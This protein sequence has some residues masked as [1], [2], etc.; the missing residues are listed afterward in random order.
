MTGHLKTLQSP[1]SRG[2]L[3]DITYVKVPIFW[4][5]LINSQ[6]QHG[7]ASVSD[8][9]ISQDGWAH[10]V[11]NVTMPQEILETFDVSLLEPQDKIPDGHV[12]CNAFMNYAVRTLQMMR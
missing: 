8:K 6:L 11:D 10:Y 1:I 4:S 7:L 2:Y 12:S 9:E 3:D 5:G